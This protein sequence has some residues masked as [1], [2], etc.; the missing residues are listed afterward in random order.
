VPSSINR[1]RGLRICRLDAINGGI[2]S[3]GLTSVAARLSVC[4]CLTCGK[5]A[6][7]KVNFRSPPFV[8]ALPPHASGVEGLV[9]IGTAWLL[10]QF[11]LSRAAGK[12]EE[13]PFIG[14]KMRGV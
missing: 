5:A 9:W 4:F 6:V 12:I 13:I 11:G 3:I 7:L 1:R 14:L 2:F 10:G 8:S